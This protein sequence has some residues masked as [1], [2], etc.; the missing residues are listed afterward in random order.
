MFRP[1]TVSAHCAETSVSAI[2]EVPKHP[3]LQFII[4]WLILGDLYY[5]RIICVACHS[6]PSNI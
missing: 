3:L 1:K 5:L 6:I 4:S 2:V